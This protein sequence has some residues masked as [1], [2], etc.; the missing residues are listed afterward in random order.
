MPFDLVLRN[1]ILTFIQKLIE[2]LRIIMEG[3]ERKGEIVF[4]FDQEMEIS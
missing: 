3:N 2:E 4:S 1:I